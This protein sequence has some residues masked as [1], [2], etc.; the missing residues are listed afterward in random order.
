M[1]VLARKPGER[2]VFTVTEPTTFEMVVVSHRGDKLRIG[3]EADPTKVD[4]VRPEAHNKEP[5]RRE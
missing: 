5:R 3:I 1:L 4:I 2:I